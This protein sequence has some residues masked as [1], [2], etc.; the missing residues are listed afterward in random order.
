MKE[1]LEQRINHLEKSW[2]DIAKKYHD[3]KTSD[4]MCDYYYNRMNTITACI[5]EL[6]EVLKK[7]EE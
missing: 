2:E 3:P 6:K 7:V 1:Y 4:K 5:R